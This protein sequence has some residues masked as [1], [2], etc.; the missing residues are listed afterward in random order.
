MIPSA[1]SGY[2]SLQD[3]NTPTAPPPYSHFDLRPAGFVP[4]QVPEHSY[5]MPQAIPLH[6][7]TAIH[8][9]QIAQA[10]RPSR[11]FCCCCSCPFWV[12]A[13]I[14]ALVSKTTNTNNIFTLILGGYY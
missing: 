14:I 4:Q 2:D 12:C 8:I 10:E 13:L 5:P 3:S 9:P 7:Q 1:T 6:N 11:C